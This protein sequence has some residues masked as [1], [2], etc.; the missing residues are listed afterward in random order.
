MTERQ[1][2]WVA[3]GIVLALWCTP[4]L[5]VKF[6]MPHYDPFAQNFLRY[7]SG[8]ALMLPLLA[9]QRHRTQAGLTKRQMLRL[10]WPTL[11]NVLH[12]T[13]WVFALQWLNPAFTSFLNKSSILFAAFL[14]YAFFPEERWL[15]RSRRFLSGAFLCIAGTAGLSLLRQDIGELKINFA[16]ILVLG[17]AAMWATYSVTVKKVA[18]E[19]GSTA[20]FAVVSVYTTI[21][22]LVPVL[23]WSD[24]GS[25]QRAPWQVNVVLV[26]SGMLSIGLGHTLYYYALKVIGVSV[27][28][29][30]LLLTPLGTLLLSRWLFGETLTAGQ[31]VSG[32]VLLT[33]GALTV[34]VREMPAP[35]VVTKAAEAADS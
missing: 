31:L 22:L 17:S 11:P 28:A 15:L 23:L 33:G 21:G 35:V 1:K 18:A 14:A 29:T 16:V 10:L 12:Q 8:V 5:F 6:L 20:S 34:L 27:C 26:L 25:W 32:I 9:W 19:I 2:A 30:M 7:A 4:T 13:G 24:T 3:L